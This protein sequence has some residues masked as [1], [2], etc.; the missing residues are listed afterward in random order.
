MWNL[1]IY[2]NKDKRARHLCIVVAALKL[3]LINARGCT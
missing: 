3:K 1:L 2:E